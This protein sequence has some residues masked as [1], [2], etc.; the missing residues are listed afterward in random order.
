MMVL[1]L[2][3]SRCHRHR[4]LISSIIITNLRHRRFPSFGT[5]VVVVVA[6][7]SSSRRETE[8]AEEETITESR[9]KRSV[10]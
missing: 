6:N 1:L 2:L 7:S 5:V 9:M 4:G 10:F 8:E 3:H